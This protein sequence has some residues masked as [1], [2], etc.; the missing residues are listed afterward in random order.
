MSELTKQQQ[1]IIQVCDETKEL[2]IKKDGNYG[3]SFSEQYKE[4]GLLSGLIR[5]DDKM[6]RLKTLFKGMDDE[7]GESTDDTLRDISGYCNLIL[8]ER[9]KE[10]ELSNGVS[11]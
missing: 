6:R 3:S 2:L 1:L 10:K 4:Y 11:K 5:L 8:V 7:V 9:L